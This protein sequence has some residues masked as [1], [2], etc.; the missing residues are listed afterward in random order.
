MKS[1]EGG[2]ESALFASDL[3]RMYVRYAER[4]GW[5]V[6]ILDANKHRIDKVLASRLPCAGYIGGVDKVFSGGGAG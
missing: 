6:E 5:R 3:A 2:E 1:G 4:H